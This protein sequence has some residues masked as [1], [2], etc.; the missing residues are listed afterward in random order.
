MHD[1]LAGALTFVTGRLGDSR[2]DPDHAGVALPVARFEVPC[3]HTAEAQAEAEAPVN[4]DAM[5][6]NDAVTP[7]ADQDDVLFGLLD[8]ATEDVSG[9]VEFSGQWPRDLMREALVDL[10]RRGLV[11][12]GRYRDLSS[13]EPSGSAPDAISETLID[14][15]A[16]NPSN[17]AWR[18]VDY[19]AMVATPAGVREYEDL[20][21]ERSASA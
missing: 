18:S 12:V 16:W 8:L 4:H 17:S 13:G 2:G 11:V 5:G 20:Y 19:M 14:E 10:S 6:D 1:P 9:L 15:D 3:S 21:R 7:P